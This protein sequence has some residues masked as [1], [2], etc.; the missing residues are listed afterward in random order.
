MGTGAAAEFRGIASRPSNF[1][2]AIRSLSCE[3]MDEPKPSLESIDDLRIALIHRRALWRER[4][5][6]RPRG[7]DDASRSVCRRVGRH[8]HHTPRQ[9]RTSRIELRGSFW[10]GAGGPRDPGRLDRPLARWTAPRRSRPYVRDHLANLRPGAGPL[11]HHLCR[12]RQ[13]GLQPDDRPKDQRRYR[14]GISRRRRYDL[15][16]VLYRDRS[17]FAALD[18]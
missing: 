15:P 3:M 18:W 2:Q 10:L 14:A 9:W 11:A 1:L 8:G 17:Q 7:E 5:G 4:A 12:S 13:A 6:R 16:M